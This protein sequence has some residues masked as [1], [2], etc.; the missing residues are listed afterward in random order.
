MSVWRFHSRSSCRYRRSGYRCATAGSQ[1]G[2]QLLEKESSDIWFT[3]SVRSTVR[4]VAMVCRYSGSHNFAISNMRNLSDVSPCG[5][6][7]EPVLGWHV[8]GASA[9]TSKD[10]QRSDRQQLCSGS[11]RD[12]QETHHTSTATKLV[13]CAL[14]LSRNGYHSSRCHSVTG[15][16]SNCVNL[17]DAICLTS[18]DQSS[19]VT[20]NALRLIQ[21]HDTA[22]DHSH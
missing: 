18:K 1:P 15:K 16:K 11:L 2:G 21:L 9:M 14:I 17:C 13:L 6:G 19:N 5:S 10:W 3:R 4:S 20:M 8:R 22:L 12:R 7:C